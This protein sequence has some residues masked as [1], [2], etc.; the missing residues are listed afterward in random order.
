MKKLSLISVVCIN[1]CGSWMT[2]GK[3][4]PTKESDLVLRNVE[5]LA[6]GEELP[7]VFECYFDGSVRCPFGDYAEYVIK[8]Y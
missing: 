1:V 7:G 2:H 4:K 3:N 5:A 6:S 8:I